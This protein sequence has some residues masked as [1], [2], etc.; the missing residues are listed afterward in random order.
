VNALPPYITHLFWF[1]PDVAQKIIQMDVLWTLKGQKHRQLAARTKMIDG[2][3]KM[4]ADKKEGQGYASARHLK[5]GY[6]ESEQPARKKA[7]HNNSL[8]IAQ[9]ECTKCGARDH[10]RVL[11]KNC[12]WKGL[13]E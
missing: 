10:K 8:T 9:Q 7:R 5:E 3:A 6:T 1:I 13:G 12:P 4:E 11:S 2:V